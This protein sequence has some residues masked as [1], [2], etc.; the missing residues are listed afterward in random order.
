MKAYEHVR[1]DRLIDF[2]RRRKFPLILLRMCV[3]AYGGARRLVVEGVC[4]EPFSIGGQSLIAGCSFATTLLKV[5]LLSVFDM[6]SRWH[7]G[8]ELH[9]FVDDVDFNATH[10]VADQAAF[11]VAKAAER[12]LT[13]FERLGLKVGIHKCMVLGSSKAVR[14]KLMAHLGGLSRACDIPL[15]SWGKKLGVQYTMQRR[16]LSSVMKARLQR[17][18]VRSNRVSRL[19]RGTTKTQRHRL[20]KWRYALL[21]PMEEP[22]GGSQTARSISSVDRWPKFME[23]KAVSAARRCSAYCG[24]SGWRILRLY[25]MLCPV[26]HGLVLFGSRDSQFR[27]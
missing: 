1:H 16:R 22:T 9:V 7:S 11:E 27:N 17:A 5:Y 21:P 14:D 19:R 15:R 20:Y 12:L 8:V 18:A 13:E 10:A 26:S 2:A 25:F 4:T 3:A 6:L 23:V 24:P